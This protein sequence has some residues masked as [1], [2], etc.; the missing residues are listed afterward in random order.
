MSGPQ[1]LTDQRPVVFTLGDNS[2]DK[3]RSFWVRPSRWEADVPRRPSAPRQH[4]SL[5]GSSSERGT[6]QRLTVNTRPDRQ[7]TN[8]LELDGH[9]TNQ[10]HEGALIGCVV[11]Y[12]RSST[13]HR[14]KP[15]SQE[16]HGCDWLRWLL[17]H[18]WVQQLQTRA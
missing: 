12:W 5:T 15:A 17:A 11:A 4:F 3:V 13:S 8:C 10:R 9:I 7:Q 18:E 16:M 2:S 1:S 14:P 6:L